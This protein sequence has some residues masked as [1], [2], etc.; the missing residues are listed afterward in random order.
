MF[1][2]LIWNKFGSRIGLFGLLEQKESL[3]EPQLPVRYGYWLFEHVSCDK[4]QNQPIYVNDHAE[5][6]WLVNCQ[7]FQIPKIVC[8]SFRF[9]TP[10]FCGLEI[11]QP[12]EQWSICRIFMKW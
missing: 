10:E 5:P 2:V 12:T 1:K 11:I 6:N 9:S 7:L 3:I 4:Q 8:N